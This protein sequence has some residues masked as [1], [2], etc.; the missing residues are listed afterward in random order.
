MTLLT[1][2]CL[3]QRLLPLD[4]VRKIMYEH[5]ILSWSGYRLPWDLQQD[6]LLMRHLSPKQE[7]L[8]Y[9][10]AKKA[11]GYYLDSS[12]D[13]DLYEKSRGHFK[14]LRP[15]SP[16]YPVTLPILDLSSSPFH[17]PHI[18]G[19]WRCRP[20]SADELRRRLAPQRCGRGGILR[21]DFRLTRTKHSL[22]LLGPHG[23]TDEPLDPL[24]RPQLRYRDH[25]GEELRKYE[26]Q[27]N[28]S[29]IDILN[30]IRSVE[31]P[32]MFYSSFY[33]R[34]VE[35]G[36]IREQDYPDHFVV[37]ELEESDVK[38]RGVGSFAET[39]KADK[40]LFS[41]MMDHI[42]DT[43]ESNEKADSAGSVKLL[44]CPS[45]GGPGTVQVCHTYTT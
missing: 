44:W 17:C 26:E 18:A 40:Q 45:M 7:D 10:V 11:R 32:V 30:H 42:I 1:Q 20:K 22:I 34:Q 43:M 28:W 29:D 27:S 13:I 16:A 33:E 9:E 12:R 21:P 31:C 41:A 3:L 35:E 25:F 37:R 36:K 23:D 19:R 8:R 39:K 6:I 4:L 5:M 38:E 14:V 15:D 2:L 24:L